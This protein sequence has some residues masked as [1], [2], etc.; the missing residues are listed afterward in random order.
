MTNNDST[1]HYTD[2]EKYNILARVRE[3]RMS[4]TYYRY[5]YIYIYIK[6]ELCLYIVN[7]SV[8]ACY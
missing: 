4:L 7:S 3:L 5:T 2:K 6:A 1:A 8:N